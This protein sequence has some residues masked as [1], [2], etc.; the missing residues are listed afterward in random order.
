MRQNYSTKCR[1]IGD[2]EHESSVM[3]N[4]EETPPKVKD[5]EKMLSDELN[6]R[7]KNAR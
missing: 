6:S 2:E 1:L 7:K 4:I 3:L 5:S